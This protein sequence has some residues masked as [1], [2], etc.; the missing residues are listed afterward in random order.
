MMSP[1]GDYLGCCVVRDLCEHLLQ[2][3]AVGQA[4]HRGNRQPVRDDD[5][6]GVRVRL[7]NVIQRLTD[8]RSQ[9][10]HRLA[11]GWARVHRVAPALV[12][13]GHVAQR[14]FVP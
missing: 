10:E 11:L 1:P 2:R 4:Q 8:A 13:L 9:L 14:H 12:Q 6:V 7:S 5:D 3:P